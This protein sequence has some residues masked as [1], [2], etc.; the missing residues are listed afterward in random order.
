MRKTFFILISSFFFLQVNAQKKIQKDIEV[1]YDKID[2]NDVWRIMHL[3]EIDISKFSISGKFKDYYCNFIIEEYKE[4]KLIS[5]HN[6]RKD[7]DSVYAFA[8]STLKIGNYLK[9]NKFEISMYSQEVNDSIIKI[10]SL[11]GGLGY[12]KKLLIDKSKLNYSWKDVL[13]IN[14]KNYKLNPDTAFPI[15]AY[16]SSVGEKFAAIPNA[17]VFCT[18]SGEAIPY[19]EWYDKLGVA[20]YFIFFVRLEK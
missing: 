20:H 15:V 7:I 4:G 13:N 18:I 16:T 9:K 11:I 12:N 6:A 19:K 3:L 14:G 8:E 2:S 5:I 1:Y 10:N 17:A